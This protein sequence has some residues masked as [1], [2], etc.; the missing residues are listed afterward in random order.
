[1]SYKSSRKIRSITLSRATLVDDPKDVYVSDDDFEPVTLTD[2][3]L[4]SLKKYKVLAVISPNP[5]YLA[6]VKP[7][8]VSRSREFE[9]LFNFGYS[10]AGYRPDKVIGIKKY[11]ETGVR[12]EYNY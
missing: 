11:D 10:G 6:L 7:Y 9:D 12:I 1:M 3:H 2:E 5:K 8:E 4:G